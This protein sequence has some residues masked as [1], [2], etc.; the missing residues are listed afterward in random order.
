MRVTSP[1]AATR[2]TGAWLCGMVLGATT[3]GLHHKLCHTL[4]GSFNLP[5]ADVHTVVLPHALAYNADRP[6]RAHCAVLVARSASRAKAI[7]CHHRARSRI[8][9]AFTARRRRWRRSACPPTVST[10]PPTSRCRTNMP[11]L[12]RWTAPRLRAL[13]QRA[14]D[15]APPQA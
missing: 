10:A 12:G 9:R 13:L 3:M 8:W 5:H 2:C 1:H 7:R 15:G 6:R 4:G 11:T 14:F